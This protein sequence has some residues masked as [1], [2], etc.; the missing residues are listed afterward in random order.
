MMWG[1]QLGADLDRSPTVAAY[2]LNLV[3]GGMVFSMHSHHC[4]S[5]VMG[6]SNF[7][8]QLADNCLAIASDTPRPPGTPRASTC[9]ASP[10]TCPRTLSSTAL[11]CFRAT[12]ATQS[13][14]RSC[15]TCPGARPPS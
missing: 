4:A 3:R 7:T 14:R 13:S 12:R 9:R 6:W 11:P 1:E 8:H 5:D 10:G 2:Q 15:S